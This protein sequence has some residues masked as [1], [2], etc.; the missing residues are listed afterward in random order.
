[1]VTEVCSGKSG[2]LFSIDSDATLF[3]GAT[4][5]ASREFPRA[6][7]TVISYL[8]LHN[9]AILLVPRSLTVLR[10]N[11]KVELGAATED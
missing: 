7:P 11:F 1:M 8:F 10:F 6:A 2:G 3:A 9:S 5:P 4:V